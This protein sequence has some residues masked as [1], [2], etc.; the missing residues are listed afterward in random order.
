MK[1]ITLKKKDI[2][3][4][5]II[6]E[7]IIGKH[8]TQV[9]F[10]DI[11]QLQNLSVF[12]YEAT[13]DFAKTYTLINE[14]KEELMKV[15]RKKA[16]DCKTSALESLKKDLK[17][18]EKITPEQTVPVDAQ[19]QSVMDDC[20]KE[21]DEEIRPE[22]EKLYNGD[23]EKDHEIEIADEKLKILIAKFE[24]FAKDLYINKKQ[25]VEVY[26]ILTAAK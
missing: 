1:T 9:D 26:G 14:K 13:G 4:L 2:L 5:S 19:A 16:Q 25:M 17:K 18:G 15:A 3:D 6:C 22:M 8:S 23:G 7:G 20:L 10:K 24:E 12:F 11:V 21:I